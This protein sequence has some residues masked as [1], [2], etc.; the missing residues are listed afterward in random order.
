[1]NDVEQWMK[2]FEK[3]SGPAQTMDNMN[4][5]LAQVRGASER[6]QQVEGQATQMQTVMQTILRKLVPLV[7]MYF[8][9]ILLLV[10]S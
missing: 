4:W 3:G 1:M 7:L 10:L 6:L 5:L 9:K 8:L 2:D